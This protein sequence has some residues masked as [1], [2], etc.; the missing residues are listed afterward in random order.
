VVQKP[1]W[2]WRDIRRTLR[3]PRGR[4][5]ICAIPDRRVGTGATLAAGG[6]LVMA[7]PCP[8]RRYT[9]YQYAGLP[10]GRWGGH[11]GIADA[12]IPRVH[13]QL[14]SGGVVGTH[15]W[16]DICKAVTSGLRVSCSPYNNKS[17]S[18]L[19][20]CHQPCERRVTPCA[21]R[22]KRRLTTSES[23]ST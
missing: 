15:K 13:Q 14:R 7:V 20:R 2:Q 9:S 16:P 22:R 12:P 3:A 19:D 8:L 10:R 6:H 18:N 5:C 23:R 17:S 21:E 4:L 11:V 1:V